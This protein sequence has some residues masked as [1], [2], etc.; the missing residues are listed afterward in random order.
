[1]SVSGKKILL[2]RRAVRSRW[3]VGV[4]DG[5]QE[6]FVTTQHRVRHFQID[7]VPMDVARLH[8]SP[9]LG[10]SAVV[11]LHADLDAGLG[12]E[13]LVDGLGAGPGI[14]AAPGDGG[15]RFRAGGVQGASKEGEGE[16]RNGA[17]RRC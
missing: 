16:N 17:S 4:V 12:G 7:H 3:E 14:G 15:H 9:D 10:Q 11:V 5:F 13:G 6:S 2:G 1:V 8:L